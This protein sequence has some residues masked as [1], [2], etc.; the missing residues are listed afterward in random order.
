MRR[1]S[2]E[3]FVC[4]VCLET[5]HMGECACCPECR[6]LKSSHGKNGCEHNS[7]HHLADFGAVAG[8]CG[9]NEPVEDILGHD[10]LHNLLAA[11]YATYIH[12]S[13]RNLVG[14]LYGRS[15][16]VGQKRVSA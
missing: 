6:H 3:G 15:P 2:D 5:V 1:E 8:L 10:A 12:I 16:L 13:T 4:G 9:C 7:D 11:A 14:H